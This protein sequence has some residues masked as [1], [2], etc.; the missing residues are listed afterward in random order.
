MDG[1]AVRYNDIKRTSNSNPVTLR[2]CDIQAPTKDLLNF[3][4]PKNHAYRISTGMSLPKGSDTVIPIENAKIVRESNYEKIEIQSSIQNGSFVFPASKDIRKGERV[5]LKGTV[6]RAQDI[7]LLAFMRIFQVPVFKKPI[8]AIIP[9][10]NELSDNLTTRSDKIPNIHSHI[11]SWLVEEIGGI[12]LDLGVTPDNLPVILN[13]IKSAISRSDLILTI[14]GSSVGKYDLVKEAIK[15]RYVSDIIAL[16][17]KLDRGRVTGLATLDGKPII[18]L[19]GPIQGAINAF[20]VFAYP[21]LRLMSGRSEKRSE[22]TIYAT[23]IDNWKAR[24]K[25]PYFTKIVYVKLVKI[26]TR[27]KFVARPLTGET[28]SMTLLTKCDGYIIVPQHVTN[29]RKGQ[30][31]EVNLMPGF[32]Y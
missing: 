4:L 26:R 6:L 25:F 30:T 10:G 16:R 2:I 19:P 32:S 29:M 7:G 22:L 23:M 13:K 1:F 12:S 9:T 21:L 31:V 8:V 5:L 11:I 14:G 15:S 27:N 20:I 18:I 3:V 28:E 17:T 24:R